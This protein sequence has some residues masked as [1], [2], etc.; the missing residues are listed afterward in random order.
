[1]RRGERQLTNL[2]HQPNLQPFVEIRRDAPN[3]I[4]RIGLPPLACPELMR[5]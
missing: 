3:D 2:R 5:L 4:A 1:M